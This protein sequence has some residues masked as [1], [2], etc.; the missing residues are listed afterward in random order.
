[1]FSISKWFEK[2]KCMLMYH[3]KSS[4]KFIF[5]APKMPL[6]YPP[7]SLSNPLSRAGVALLSQCTSTHWPNLLPSNYNW[8]LQ[9]VHDT[10]E[11]AQG[12]HQKSCRD[13]LI[14]PDPQ[15]WNQVASGCSVEG[16]LGFDPC[17]WAGK[18]AH[19]NSREPLSV[20][21]DN[22]ELNRWMVW[23]CLQELF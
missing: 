16:G 21:S 22:A 2:W 10:W 18:G 12:T 11:L 5:P 17:N 14:W 4:I 13:P 1:M 20:S 9:H 15:F 7:A 19:W 23:P 8:A 3:Y 6:F